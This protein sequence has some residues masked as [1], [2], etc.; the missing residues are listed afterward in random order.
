MTDDTTDR[1]AKA[2]RKIIHDVNTHGWHV[3]KVMAEGDEPGWAYT[4]GLFRTQSQPE[5]LIFGLADST[6]HRILNDIGERIRGGEKF[7]DG[8]E[9]HEILNGYPL[10][11]RAVDRVWYRWI[12][13]YAIWFY[14]N[15]EFPAAQVLWPDKTGRFPWDTGCAPDIARLQPLLYESDPQRARGSWCIRG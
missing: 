3:M 13:G 4:I 11:F 15:H 7:P 2:D 14:G 12:F 1:S 10:V 9:D 5:L 8:S 6:M